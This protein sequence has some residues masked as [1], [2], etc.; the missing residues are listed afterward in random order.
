MC[1]VRADRFINPT[2]QWD[3]ASIRYIFF[4]YGHGEIRTHD[5]VKVIVFKTIVL[6]RSTT[7]PFKERKGKERKGKEVAS[8]VY[9]HTLLYLYPGGS[10]RQPRRRRTP[11]KQRHVVNPLAAP[12]EGRVKRGPGV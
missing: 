11:S 10:G 8:N 7:C 3:N 4:L 12:A 1:A 6:N 2:L 9:P 5:S